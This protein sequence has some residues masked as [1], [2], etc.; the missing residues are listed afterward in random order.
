MPSGEELANIHPIPDDG[1]SIAQENDGS[2][3]T[4]WPDSRIRVDEPDGRSMVTFPD[5]SVLN[6]ETD[7]TRILNDVNGK[8]LDR[9]TGEPLSGTPEQLLKPKRASA[10]QSVSS[11]TWWSWAVIAATFKPSRTI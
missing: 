10:L 6:I 9:V 8:P 5:F 11:F 7:G 2:V 3:T 1:A 4:S